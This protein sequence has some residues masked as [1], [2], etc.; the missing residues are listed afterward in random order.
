MTFDPLSVHDE[1]KPLITEPAKP[2]K[3][4]PVKAEEKKPLITET[5]PTPERVEEK[6]LDEPARPPHKIFTE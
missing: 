6:R 3:A 2:A 5:L 4:A 1:K